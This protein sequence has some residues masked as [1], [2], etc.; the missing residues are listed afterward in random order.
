MR[1]LPGFGLGLGLAWK[2]YMTC[3]FCR[4]LYP[5]TIFH[6]PGPSACQL[7]IHQKRTGQETGKEPRRHN[8]TLCLRLCN[9]SL[10]EEKRSVLGSIGRGV[11][12]RRACATLVVVCYLEREGGFYVGFLFV[13]KDRCAYL[14]ICWMWLQLV[15]VSFSVS[16][17]CGEM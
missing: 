2:H 9:L 17:E 5:H 11:P 6:S 16:D 13:E 15:I 12:V 4:S 14:L 10:H 8:C 3:C 1:W 7:T